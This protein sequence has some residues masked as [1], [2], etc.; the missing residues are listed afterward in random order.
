V[1]KQIT[2]GYN[3][4]ILRVNLSNNDIRTETIS[5]DFCRKYLGGAGFIAHFLWQ[6]LEK[7]IDPLGPKNKLIFAVGPLTGIPLSGTGRNCIGTKSPLTGGIAKSEVGEYWGAELK[8]AG[9]DALIIEGRSEKPVYLS[10]NDNEVNI[11][12]AGEIWGK[13]TKET[14]QAIRDNLGDRRVRVASIGPGGENMVLYACIMNG[15]YDA[16]GRGGTGAVMGSKNLKAIAVRGKQALPKR[17]DKSVNDLKN[18]LADNMQMIRNFWEVGTGLAMDGLEELGILPVHNFRDRLF[19]NAKKIDATTIK[20]TIRIRMDACYACKV[21]CKK[22]VKVD[23]PY[24]VDPAYGGP[25]YETLASLGSNCGIDDLAAISKGSELCNAY[26]LDTISAGSAV[27][28]AMECYEN[29]LLTTR[30]TDGIELKFGNT[31]AMLKL[32]EMIA[33]RK[34]I[35]NLLAD[36]V[37]RAAKEIG[38]GAEEYALEVKGLDAGMHDPRAKPGLGIGFMLNPHGADHA[39]NL[40]DH[41]Y[42][43]ENDMRVKEAKQLG[44][45]VPLVIDDVGPN[46]VQLVRF[47]QLRTLLFDSLVMCQFL[48]YNLTQLNEV[49]AS[50]TGWDTDIDELLKISER[51][52]TT[53]RL[54]NLSEG[55]SADDDRLPS[56]FY[57]QKMDARPSDKPL[58]Q[59]KLKEARR[60]YYSIMGWDEK[61]GIP[62]PQKL[63]E[64]GIK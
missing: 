20:N 41:M 52:L 36:G 42:L 8:R 17:G 30:D 23:K 25:E 13:K 61:S 15:L 28:F 34:G 60:Y 54:I 44:L 49:L 19:P 31:E 7:G 43:N 2:N 40:H 35:G 33:L 16:A 46:K 32:L 56:R 12:D 48:P 45:P 24:N 26:S 3:G 11:E 59:Q 38:G 50:I 22:V 9:Y 53:F 29:G 57:Q 5:D 4:K 10:I 62:E 14:Q 1:L 37:A 47:C 51:T 63:T 39:S 64:L 58:D 27:S 18:W 21:H 55:F 6:E